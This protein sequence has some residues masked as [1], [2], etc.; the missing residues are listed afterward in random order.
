MAASS[1]PADVSGAVYFWHPEGNNG[2]MSQWYDSPWTHEGTD[3]STA[4]MWMMVQKAKLF[5]DDVRNSLS[6]YA[7]P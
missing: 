2:F 5:K 6:L 7:T 3:Y 1:V 4:E